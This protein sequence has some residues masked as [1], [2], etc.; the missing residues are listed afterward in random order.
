LAT[1]LRPQLSIMHLGILWNVPKSGIS[2][3]VT[4]SLRV[5]IIT[6]LARD[7]L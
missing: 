5:L 1:V 6:P 3:D 4:A 7:H 2:L